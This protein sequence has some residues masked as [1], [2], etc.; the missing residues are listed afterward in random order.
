[1][2]SAGFL[3]ISL[4]ATLLVIAPGTVLFFRGWRSGKV[5]RVFT[6]FALL[7]LLVL[8]GFAFTYP[9][10]TDVE[11]RVFAVYLACGLVVYPGVALYVC[12]QAI[13]GFLKERRTIVRDAL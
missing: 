1:M 9:E 8:G 4:V 7:L 6:F 5:G 2:P 11:S 10:T 13:A 12:I 3:V